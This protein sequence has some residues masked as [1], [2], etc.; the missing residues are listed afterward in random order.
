MAR[1]DNSPWKKQGLT[2]AQ[3][4][5]KKYLEE[6]ERNNKY[7]L[8]LEEIAT[9]PEEGVNITNIFSEENMKTA[10]IKYI[11]QEALK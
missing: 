9:Y 7:K 10:N 2:E 6:L 11:A 1:N 3:Y 8:A 4:F 5:K